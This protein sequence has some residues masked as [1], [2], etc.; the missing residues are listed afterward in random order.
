MRRYLLNLAISLD[1]LVNTILLGHPDETISSRTGRAAARGNRW[2]RYVIAP[3]IDALFWLLGDGP[4]HC[5]RSIE[6]R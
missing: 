1:Q 5:A 4:D 2:A 6:V 3:S